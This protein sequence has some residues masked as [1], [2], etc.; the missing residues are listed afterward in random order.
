MKKLTSILLLSL[1]LFSCLKDHENDSPLTGVTISD[2]TFTFDET[3]KVIDVQS[4]FTNISAKIIDTKTNETA[5]WLTVK[6]AKGK[7][8]LN[9]EEN[10]TICDRQAKVTLYM[11]GSREH[12]SNPDLED[13][14]E[15]LLSGK[16]P[17]VQF[18]KGE[19][20]DASGLRFAVS[21]DGSLTDELPRVNPEAGNWVID[22]GVLKVYTDS[23]KTRI[24]DQEIR[25]LSPDRI[26]IFCHADGKTY[27][28]NREVR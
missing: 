14:R 21:E 25:I 18:L 12:V 27:T 8:T 26:E 1:L 9:T 4:T 7:L 11:D 3:Q 22:G 19:W 28:L 6:L 10:T 15:A 16:I 24:A 23:S 20:R 17:A 13:T 5:S 2:V